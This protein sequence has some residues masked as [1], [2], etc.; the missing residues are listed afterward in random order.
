MSYANPIDTRIVEVVLDDLESNNAH[1]LCEL[2]AASYGLPWSVP[3]DIAEEA[4]QAAAKVIQEHN[5]A[6]MRAVSV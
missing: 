3:A 2:L 4:Y 6:K 5:Y 1:T